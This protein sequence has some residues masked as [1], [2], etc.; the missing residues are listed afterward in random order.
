MM[1]LF[2]GSILG[3]AVIVFVLWR[4]TR[5]A[6]QFV[7]EIDGQ[8]AR[9]VEG[10]PP[11]WFVKDVQRIAAFSDLASGTIRAVRHGSR[12]RLQFSDDIAEGNRWQFRNAWR[13]PME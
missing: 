10:D 7:I 12:V 13:N 1:P 2:V 6:V 4:L 11:D 3:V 8:D 5:G 9:V